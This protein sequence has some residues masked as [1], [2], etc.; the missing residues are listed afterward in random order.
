[1]PFPNWLSGGFQKVYG[2]VD[3]N[4]AGGLLPGGADSPYVGRSVLNLNNQ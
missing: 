3:K 1:M 4:L 2:A